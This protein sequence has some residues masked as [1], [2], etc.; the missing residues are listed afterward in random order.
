MRR[1]GR[2][3]GGAALLTEVV[4]RRT[5]TI[6]AAGRLTPLGADLLCGTVDDL[7]NRGWHRITVEL[8]E[9]DTADASA[10]GLLAQLQARMA[11]GG[12]ELLL[13]HLDDAGD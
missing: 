7:R 11:A 3:A 13:E 8:G 9:V 2:P 6:R 1:P 12:A 5:G 4:D 10:R